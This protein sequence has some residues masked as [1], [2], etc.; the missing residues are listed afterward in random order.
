MCALGP[1][2]ANQSFTADIY[3]DVPE[4]TNW[5][6]VNFAYTSADYSTTA[7]YTFKAP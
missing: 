7:V 5:T 4:G 2:G 6:S 3:F 1:V